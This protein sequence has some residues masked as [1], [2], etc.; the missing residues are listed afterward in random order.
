MIQVGTANPGSG[1]ANAEAQGLLY[2]EHEMKK[3]QSIILIA[4]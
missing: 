2:P 3:P 4:S 1:E